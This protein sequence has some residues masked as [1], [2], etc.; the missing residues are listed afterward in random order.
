MN[1][2]IGAYFLL[3]IATASI[4]VGVGKDN[5]SPFQRWLILIAVMMTFGWVVPFY[6]GR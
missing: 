4:I 2:M 5:P 6:L 3:S 1:D